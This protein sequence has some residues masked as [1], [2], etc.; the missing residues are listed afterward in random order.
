[1]KAAQKPGRFTSRRTG[2]HDRP[3]PN[4]EAWPASPIPAAAQPA[5]AA[6]HPRSGT[7]LSA[8]QPPILLA[9]TAALPHVTGSPDLEVLRRL[10]PVPGRS[11]DHEPSPT[12][13][14][15]AQHKGGPGTVPVF[16]H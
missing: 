16:T 14:P 15:A 6:R 10:R 7:H 8:L 9:T 13:T 2:G 11:A 3:P 12:A 5:G 1:M 4:G